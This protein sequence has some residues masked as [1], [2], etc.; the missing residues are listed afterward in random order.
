M[1]ENSS[2]NLIHIGAYGLCLDDCDRLLLVRMLE[3]PDAGRWT[4]PGGGVRWGED[5]GQAVF[6]EMEE[7]TGLVNLKVNCVA[8]VYS[9]IYH[10]TPGV[11]LPPLHHVGIVYQLDALTYELR[12]EVG[13]STDLCRWLKETE[14]RS[15][16]LTPLGKYG[17]ELAWPG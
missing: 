16:P 11:L 1:S 15:L 17:L 6:R 7:E 2:G 9:H 3:G 5:P 14:V 13:G 8:A 4:L 12:N 10:D